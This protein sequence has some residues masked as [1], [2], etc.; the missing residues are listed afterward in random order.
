MRS[1]KGGEKFEAVPLQTYGYEYGGNPSENAA[2]MLLTMADKQ[3][4]MNNTLSGG[5]GRVKRGGSS[6]DRIEI[7]QFTIPGPKVSVQNANSSSLQL[8]SILINAENDSSNDNKI[9]QT[10]G[11]HRKTRKNI[12][13]K[14]KRYHKSSSRCKNHKRSCKHKKSKIH[15]HCR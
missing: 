9:G 13:K 2:K 1:L 6:Q 5:R 15:R 4:S 8:N 12:R 14:N 7:P 3:N 10:G 11:R